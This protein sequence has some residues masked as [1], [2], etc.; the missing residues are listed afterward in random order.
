MMGIDKDATDIWKFGRVR[1]DLT[2]DQTCAAPM[3][4]L[5]DEESNARQKLIDAHLESK[6]AALTEMA[7]RS[8]RNGYA[9]ARRA[10]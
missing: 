8:Y 2:L 10:P 4:E 1:N 5:S 9:F 6:L 3:P 7:A